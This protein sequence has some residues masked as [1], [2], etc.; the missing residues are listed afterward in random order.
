MSTSIWPPI[1]A[2][3]LKKE[4]DESA[5]R[6]LSW[7]LDSLQE[8]L[9]SLK[10][11]LEECYALL[12]PIE[13]GST[14]V[15][16]SP[17]SESIKG[18]ITRVGTRIVKGSL[19]L[20]LKTH[21]P[22]HPHLSPDCPLILPSL[23]QLRTL[24]NESLDCVDITRW[25]GDRHSAPFISSQLH[26]LHTI[27]LEALSLLKGPSLLEPIPISP[28][29][30]PSPTPGVQKTAIP[31]T[32]HSAPDTSWFESPP[33]P[34]TFVPALPSTLSLALTLSDTSLVLTI[35]TL[36]PTS[37]QPNLGSRFAF[38]I[39][40][41]RRLEHDEMDDVFMYRDEEVRVKEKIRVEGSADPSLLSLGAKLGALERTVESARV[42]L[43]VVVG[44][45]TGV[46]AEGSNN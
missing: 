32:P 30:S 15:M 41:Q 38:A 40:A 27:I 3:A 21:P 19:H 14:L 42:G 44:L 4:E 1:A 46:E 26:L 13:P 16:S 34:A 5:A 37:L 18:H 11:G 23:S 7:L 35:R 36:E 31:Q 2:D 17:R 29:N 10:S 45:G 22:T 12:A 25:T 8:T 39:G 24:L 33:D 43:G 20:R 6:E 9:A 28:S